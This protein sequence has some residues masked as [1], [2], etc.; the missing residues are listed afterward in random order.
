M[1]EKRKQPIVTDNRIKTKIDFLVGLEKQQRIDPKALPRTPMH[2]EDAD[3]ATQALRYIAEDQ[4]YDGKRSSVWRNLLV[5]G[6]G[7]IRVYVEP[8]RATGYGQGEMEIKI[9]YVAWDRCSGTR[10]SSRPDFSDAAYLG[11]VVWMDYSDALA[12][13]PDGKDA[14]DTTMASATHTDTYDDKPKFSSWADKKRKRVR[15]CQMW[16]KRDDAWH[17]AEFTK[18]GIFKAARRLT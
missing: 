5:E 7:G 18:G 6:A 10:I 16:I 15:I 1:L 12:R 11:I 17:F 3:G 4:D 13:Y 9:D 14:L 2:E 8:S